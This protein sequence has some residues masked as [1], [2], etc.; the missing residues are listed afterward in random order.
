MEL[1]RNFYRYVI[2]ENWLLLKGEKAQAKLEADNWA[3]ADADEA[4]KAAQKGMPYRRY[5]GEIEEW[6]ERFDETVSKMEGG[7]PQRRMS[8]GDEE[9]AELPEVP[10]PMAVTFGFSMQRLADQAA[11]AN[12]LIE[13]KAWR[14]ARIDELKDRLGVRRS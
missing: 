3:F 1:L 7:D 14:E 9:L 5:L 6:K 8:Y 4:V 10:R 13:T 2:R 11:M 12:L